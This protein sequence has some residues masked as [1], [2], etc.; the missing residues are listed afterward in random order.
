MP[1]PAVGR[2]GPAVPIGGIPPGGRNPEI[3]DED[4]HT[5]KSIYYIYTTIYYIYYRKTHLY[6]FTNG[7]LNGS[8]Y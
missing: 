4:K 7:N 5:S 1:M 8:L 3:V 6:L 2:G